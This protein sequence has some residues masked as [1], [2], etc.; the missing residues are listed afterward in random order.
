VRMCSTKLCAIFLASVLVAACSSRLPYTPDELEQQAAPTEFMDRAADDPTLADLVRASG[1]DGQWPPEQWRLSTLT[2]VGLYFNPSVDV[3]RAQAV[4]ATA[5]LTTASQRAPV[6]VELAAEHHSREVEGS[7]WSLGLAVGLPIGTRNR[8]EARV[9]KASLLADAAE[10]EIAASAWRVRSAVRDAVIDYSASSQ[11]VR[12]AQ[13]RLTV[14]DE[15]LQLLQRRV[16]AGMLSSRELGRERMA[17]AM[18]E[19]DL[20]VEKTSRANALGALAGALG[21]PLETVRSFRIADN[22]LDESGAVP[23][24]ATARAEALRNRLDVHVSL[25]EYGAA[26]AELR[27][28][29]AEQYPVVVLTPGF[30]WDQGDNIW[31]L[32]SAFVVPRSALAAVREAEAR[33][34]VAA[35]Q[36]T[37]LQIRAINEVERAREALRVTR[38]NV[39]AGA[40]VVRRAQ[41]QLDRAKRY[42]D[43]GGGDRVQLVTARLA[44]L[45]ARQHLLDARTVWRKSIA[46]F[47]D[48]M[49][50]P[51]FGDFLNLPDQPTVTGAS[52]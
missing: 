24:A 8:L 23:E 39:D 41:G 36:F 49:Q 28:A 10:L 48:V 45:Q 46:R 20:A 9:M 21:L 34:D 6:S 40:D 50:R 29:V 31:S 52:T 14:H 25:L 44:A 43:A 11:R 15:L 27:L 38:A 2:L 32:A 35:K 7:P 37:A 16:D 42:F 47:E 12:L 33:R 3:A 30:L 26:D 18:A 51:L 19:A 5:A 22:P 17:R 4:A 13:Q 1:Y